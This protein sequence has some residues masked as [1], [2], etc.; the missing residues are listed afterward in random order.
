MEGASYVLAAVNCILC[1]II[2]SEMTQV[3]AVR[4]DHSSC[5]FYL[6]P[7]QPLQV[8]WQK[9]ESAVIQL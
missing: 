1:V 3:D 4:E 6:S 7:L 2:V 9:K 8:H 5:I